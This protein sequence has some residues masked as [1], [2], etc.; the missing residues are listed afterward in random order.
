MN[1]ETQ[2][3]LIDRLLVHLANGTSEMMAGEQMIASNRYFAPAF[4]DREYRA[5]FRRLPLVIGPSSLVPQ[6]GDFHTC[7]NYGLPV[8]LTRTADGTL[9]A[10]VNA[11]T[12]RGARLVSAEQGCGRNAFTCPYHGWTFGHDG[13]LRH[14]PQA[15]GF[16]QTDKTTHGLK[17][18]PAQ[19]RFGLIWVALDPAAT[20][21]VD[22]YVG[23]LGPE[24]AALGLDRHV[25]FRTS[26]Q[27]FAGNWKFA[28]ENLL[29]AYHVPYAHAETVHKALT[30]SILVDRF[31][32]HQRFVAA[33]HE[34][35][36]LVG[37]PR[38]RWRLRAC[39]GVGYFLFPNTVLAVHPDHILWQRA[40]PTGPQAA[41]SAL[42]PLIPATAQGGD[43]PAIWERRLRHAD[44]VVDE[45]VAITEPIGR[46]I[47]AGLHP[48]FRI[49]RHELAIAAFHAGIDQAMATD[50]GGT[51]C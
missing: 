15:G 2:Q 51:L 17:R 9:Q 19:E 29:E 3:A 20:L 28:M 21:D 27:A 46:G 11:C 7:D 18:L 32:L 16:P 43:W 24:L 13:Q 47:T 42:T 5:L 6:P 49:G 45:D 10:F 44:Q 40:Y 30:G 23:P 22:A 33:R 36:K 37:I 48:G 38:H 26:R 4:F 1:I 34:V 39:G 8:L 14:I 31:G 50:G 41:V 35:A 25:A 12:H